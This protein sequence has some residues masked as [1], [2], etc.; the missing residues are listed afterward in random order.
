MAQIAYRCTSASDIKEALKSI[1]S[2]YNDIVI[3]DEDNI[4]FYFANEPN[5][6]FNLDILYNYIIHNT[7]P[8]QRASFV[9]CSIKV[10]NKVIFPYNIDYECTDGKNYASSTYIGDLGGTFTL[11]N[12]LTISGKD[13]Y[14]IFFGRDYLAFVRYVKGQIASYLICSGRGEQDGEG[15]YILSSETALIRQSDKHILN[16]IFNGSLLCYY[17]KFGIYRPNYPVDYIDTTYCS[18]GYDELKEYRQTVPAG[19][20]YATVVYKFTHPW[21]GN[22]TC[23]LLFD[24]NFTNKLP[25]YNNLVQYLDEQNAPTMSNTLNG[26]SLLLPNYFFIDAA[27]LSTHEYKYV[28][29]TP[30]MCYC[31]MYN[32]IGG[33]IV[34]QNYPNYGNKFMCFPLTTDNEKDRKAGYY[35]GF[36]FMLPTR[37]DEI[38]EDDEELEPLE[39]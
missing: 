29:D 11:N 19:Q 30:E 18:I 33:N 20:G 25:N 14:Y 17:N 10:D 38:I 9:V 27:P 31:S 15:G 13:E 8:V 23:S 6:V 2:Q 22:C 39:I 3:N 4:S 5:V 12:C 28:F 36:A 21:Y 1:T 35:K 34:Q 24:E 7:N 26:I 37:Y 32:M 16:K